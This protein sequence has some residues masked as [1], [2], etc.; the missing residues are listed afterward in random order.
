MGTNFQHLPKCLQLYFDELVC[1]G[2]LEQCDR[3]RV[4]CIKLLFSS[5]FQQWVTAVTFPYVVE[6]S[7]SWRPIRIYSA[8]IRSIKYQ[9]NSWDEIRTEYRVTQ[10]TGLLCGLHIWQMQRLRKRHDRSVPSTLETQNQPEQLIERGP[11]NC[12]DEYERSYP[13]AGTKPD[14]PL[15][16]LYEELEDLLVKSAAPSI[17]Q[18]HRHLTTQEQFVFQPPVKWDKL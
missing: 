6:Y 4:K 5:I 2:D 7:L 15:L 1:C 17:L 18:H 14:L 10:F 3:S 8:H 13:T 16:T 12:W 9:I 11:E